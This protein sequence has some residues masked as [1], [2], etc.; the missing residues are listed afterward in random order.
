[1]KKIFVYLVVV[2]VVILIGVYLY[3]DKSSI[4]KD[5][6]AGEVQ[7]NTNG[8]IAISPNETPDNVE[9]VVVTS[10][11]SGQLVI[12]PLKIEGYLTNENQ[13]NGWAVF[14]GEAGSVKI[15]DGNGRVMGEAILTVT[16]QDWMEKGLNGQ[17]VR[18]EAMVGDRQWMSNLA[19]SNGE[20]VITNMRAADKDEVMEIR[21]P[22]RFR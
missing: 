6:V 1:M 12:M 19:T 15:V 4:Q 9:S 22:V 16:D 3:S 5:V 10:V 8:N 14:E 20:I 7:D 21:I 18:F 2:L 11:T 13:P 17:K